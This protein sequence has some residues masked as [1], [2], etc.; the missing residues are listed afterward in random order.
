MTALTC[1]CRRDFGLNTGCCILSALNYV[2]IKKEK[3]KKLL[4]VKSFKRKDEI[5]QPVIRLF[6]PLLIVSV[7]HWVLTTLA[8]LAAFP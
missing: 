1:L 2:L 7:M 6:S 5:C 4:Q 8:S 3:K